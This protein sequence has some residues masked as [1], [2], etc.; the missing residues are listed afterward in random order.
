[1]ARY[2]T[3]VRC[4]ADPEKTFDDLADF[5][6]V[7]Q[8]DPGVVRAK[9][10][11]DGPLGVGSRF[12]VVVS[13]FGNESA[14]TYEITAFER[15]Y[16]VVLEASNSLLH[17]HDE[18]RVQPLE[19]GCRVSYDAKLTLRGPLALADPL[20]SLAFGRIGDQAAEGL[21]NRLGGVI[22]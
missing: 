9:R 11:D 20:L 17:S 18:I 3:T 19:S 21:R 4:P 13:T 22:D 10:L 5:Q 2:E 12:R 8:W 7:Q 14:L 16:R 6:T 15:P 1:M